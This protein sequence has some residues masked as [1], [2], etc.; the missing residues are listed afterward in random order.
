MWLT[1]RQMF[2]PSEARGGATRNG[3]AM[4]CR[5]FIQPAECMAE[6]DNAASRSN[7][8]AA[9]LCRQ[10]N[11]SRSQPRVIGARINAIMIS[12]HA[13][14]APNSAATTAHACTVRLL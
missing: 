8:C 6:P 2:A 3:T 13:S 5:P 9:P 4:H 1:R 14:R 11:H 12:N 10:F 7:H